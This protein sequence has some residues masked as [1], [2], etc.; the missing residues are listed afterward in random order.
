MKRAFRILAVLVLLAVIGVSIAFILS[1]SMVGPE[2]SVEMSNVVG[3]VFEPFLKR[4]YN[5]FLRMC[6][7][8]DLPSA[9]TYEAFVRKLAHFIEYLALGIGC[10]ILTSLLAKG[11]PWR[12]IWADLFVVLAVA[13]VDELIQAYTG[14]GSRLFDVVIDF[15]GALVGV[16]VV[17]TIASVIAIICRGR[18][19]VSL[20]QPTAVV[21]QPRE[22]FLQ[23]DMEIPQP[24]TVLPQSDMID[25][26]SYTMPLRSNDMDT[27][28][29]RRIQQ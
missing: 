14:R 17:V 15:V 10:A 19:D 6:A 21:Q 3:V 20:R 1:N 25:T 4:L 12:L 2:E 28:P 5:L 24:Y 22:W 11:R 8:A 23:S 29:M 13:V 16:L 27:Q 18:D 26:K 7:W 9:T